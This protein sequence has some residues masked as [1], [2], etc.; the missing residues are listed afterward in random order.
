MACSESVNKPTA[1]VIKYFYENFYFPEPCM[2]GWKVRLVDSWN[3]DT[4][5]KV[6]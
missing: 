6:A 5:L 3:Y 1:D 4:V 2:D